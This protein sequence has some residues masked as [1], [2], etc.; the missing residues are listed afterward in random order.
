MAW[1]HYLPYFLFF[2]W[3]SITYHSVQVM[4]ETKFEHEAQMK[5]NKPL[6]YISHYSHVILACLFALFFQTEIVTT[7][8][9]TSAIPLWKHLLGLS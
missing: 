4:T 8:A 7:G 5:V 1:L 2:V 3:L 6:F 9:K